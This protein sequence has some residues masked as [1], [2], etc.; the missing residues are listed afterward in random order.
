[1]RMFFFRRLQKVFLFLLCCFCQVVLGRFC[2][3]E[4]ICTFILNIGSPRWRPWTWWW[5]WEKFLWIGE[6]LFCS[7]QNVKV[8]L[9]WNKKDL[10][11]WCRLLRKPNNLLTEPLCFTYK[12]KTNSTT[13]THFHSFCLVPS[14]LRQSSTNAKLLFTLQMCSAFIKWALPCSSIGSN[15]CAKASAHLWDNKTKHF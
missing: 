7:V 2:V 10:R 13:S 6:D 3:M 14:L 9:D 11:T 12:Q 5:D 1:M 15:T 8:R 4:D